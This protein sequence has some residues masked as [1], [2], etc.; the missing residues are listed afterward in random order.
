MTSKF[1]G[2]TILFVYKDKTIVKSAKDNKFIHCRTDNDLMRELKKAFKSVIEKG[3]SKKKTCF[4]RSRKAIEKADV[5]VG[6]G[7][8]GNIDDITIE[9]TSLSEE[10]FIIGIG[11]GKSDDDEN[12]DKR[13]KIWFTDAISHFYKE[14][15]NRPTTIHFLIDTVPPIV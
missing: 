12:A 10:K 7:Y 4:S 9:V 6:K 5:E 3:G 1:R 11:L 15:K 13:N 8:E 14:L 2:K